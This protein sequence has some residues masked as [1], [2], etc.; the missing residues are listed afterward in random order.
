MFVLS[1]CLLHWV[2]VCFLSFNF[3]FFSYV[4][5]LMLL[6]LLSSLF[7]W[8]INNTDCFQLVHDHCV[9]DCL[10]VCL[11]VWLFVCLP[12]CLHSPGSALTVDPPVQHSEP[13]DKYSEIRIGNVSV[14]QW[15][16]MTRKREAAHTSH[17]SQVKE[18]I[19]FFQMD[20]KE[21][22]PF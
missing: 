18:S 21:T 20:L 15:N 3:V 4:C 19:K 11:L 2:M 17:V 8:L 10:F 7:E 14:S 22:T 9:F 6:Y 16:T 1:V 13:Y 12:V 5:K